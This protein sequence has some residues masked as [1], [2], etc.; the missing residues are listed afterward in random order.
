LFPAILSFPS[1]E[2]GAVKRARFMMLAAVLG[3]MLMSL[4]GFAAHGE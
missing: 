4:N 3:F 1:T 2:E